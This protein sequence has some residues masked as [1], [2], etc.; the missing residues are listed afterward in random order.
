MKLLMTPLTAILVTSALL[1][2][3]HNAVAADAGKANL[4]TALRF[5]KDGL[6]KADMKVFDEVL[7]PDVVVVTGL[8]SKEPIRGRD[9]YKKVFA[10]F[11]DAWPVDSFVIDNIFAAGDKVVVQ[12]TA[13]AVFRKDYFGVK[14]NNVMAPMKEVQVYTFRKGKIVQ[15]V[16]GAINY[17]FEF[18]MFPALKDAVLGDLQSA[19]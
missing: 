13:N 1:A 17:P 11:A 5:A 9:N 6:G 18:T 4:A 15:N 8:S 10:G 7:D 19:K 12:F 16:V 3:T 2:G 14:A